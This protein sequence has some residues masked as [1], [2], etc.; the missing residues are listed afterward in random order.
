[1]EYNGSSVRILPYSTLLC[2]IKTQ[3][4]WHV[5]FFQ[6]ICLWRNWIGG[7]HSRGS[8]KSK[9][10]HGTSCEADILP[11]R[12]LL[13]TIGPLSRNGCSIQQ[14]WIGIRGKLHHQRRRIAFCCGH[15]T[16]KDRGSGPCD[17]RM[18]VDF[19]VVSGYFWYVLAFI[20]LDSLV[21]NTKQII[22]SPQEHSIT[23]PL[24]G[25]HLRFWLE[26]IIE[27]F[28][29][30]QWSSPLHFACWHIWAQA[31]VQRSCS[32]ILLLWFPLSVRS[33]P[34]ITHVSCKNFE[35]WLLHHNY[36][37]CLPGFPYWSPTYTSPVRSNYNKYQQIYSPTGHH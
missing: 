20:Y 24:M 36:Q 26:Q 25:T 35:C 12:Y 15:Q 21:A 6:S 23:L 10:G 7:R 3:K 33:R 32:V 18:P 22:I 37:A 19:C 34:L 27:V 17:Q 9:A 28:Q 1:M 2:T 14:L 30:L 31:L 5:L 11:H 29:S 13:H 8:S 16:R 4:C